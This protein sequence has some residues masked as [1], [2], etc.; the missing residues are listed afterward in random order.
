MADKRHATFFGMQQHTD[1]FVP[2]YILS[3]NAW[4]AATLDGGIGYLLPVVEKVYRRLLMLQTKLT[5][6]LPHAA[7]LNPKAFRM[8]HSRYQYLY[9]A[10]RNILDGELLMNYPQL[11]LKQ[12]T[13][14]AKQIGTS[15]AQILDDLKEMDKITT[16][17]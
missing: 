14:F 12:R 9:T 4:H 13:D 3:S 5:S 6:G 15:P 11:S 16:R 1:K 17:F 2:V 8:F 7:G 10:Q